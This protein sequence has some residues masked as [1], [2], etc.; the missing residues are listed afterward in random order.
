MQKCPLVLYNIATRY[1][2]L[3]ITKEEVGMEEVNIIKT[4]GGD[5]RVKHIQHI[6]ADLFSLYH[7]FC[8]T[9]TFVINKYHVLNF[10][11]IL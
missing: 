8:D 10:D 1:Y 9:L 2:V 11:L 5:N 3:Y 7:L 6:S 4:T